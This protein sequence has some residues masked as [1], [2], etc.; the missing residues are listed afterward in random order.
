MGRGWAGAG[1][2]RGGGVGQ[3]GAAGQGQIR[4]CSRSW[5]SSTTCMCVFR[6]ALDRALSSMYG[7]DSSVEPRCTLGRGP[8]KVQAR[9]SGVVA[10]ACYLPPPRM[11]V[12]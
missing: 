3:S 11:R 8:R 9:G 5:F 4:V 6:L 1:V 12:S 7:V 10:A 2:G